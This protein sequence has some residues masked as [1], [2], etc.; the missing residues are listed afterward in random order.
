M[1]QVLFDTEGTEYLC[2][3]REKVI[4]YY[5][6]VQ[7]AIG[8]ENG[9]TRIEMEGRKMAMRYF[10]G[11][12]CLSD[13][14]SS[15]QDEPK[16]PIGSIVR[17]TNNKNPHYGHKG[18]FGKVITY[19]AKF[20]RYAIAG[21]P[22]EKE[23]GDLEPYTE[24]EKGNKEEES[25][26][27]SEIPNQIKVMEEKELN[28]VELLKD[29]EGEEFYSHSYGNVILEDIVVSEQYPM[30]VRP[31]GYDNIRREA[32]YPNGKI[33]KYGH[34]DLFP[35]RALYEKY[36]LDPYSAWMEWNPERT[37][38]RWRAGRGEEYW[39]IIFD[40]SFDNSITSSF[41][42]RDCIDN[43]NYDIGNYFKDEQTAQQAAEAV[44]ECLA[45]FHESISQTK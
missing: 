38:K 30:V 43:A 1:E 41:D 32:Y 15:V 24:P 13:K 4:E 10:F 9:D 3:E 29:C 22:G 33:S 34:T 27:N 45:K 20:K 16:F 42:V 2:V 11:D 21:I 12:K 44:R 40:E 19:N 35:S 25:G 7:L 17:I 28:L 18:K 36:P 31:M 14:E 5:K 6:D 39:R 23:E 37:H 8:E 26:N